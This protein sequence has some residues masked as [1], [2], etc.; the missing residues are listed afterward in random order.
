VPTPDPREKG[1]GRREKGEGRREEREGS[2][3][4]FFFLIPRTFVVL[5][6]TGWEDTMLLRLYIPL[7]LSCPGARF[8][9][10]SL[11]VTTRCS[12]PLYTLSMS[13]TCYILHLQWRVANGCAGVRY[14]VDQPNGTWHH[15]GYDSNGLA[16]LSSSSEEGALELWVRNREV[17]NPGWALNIP[18]GQPLD[19]GTSMQ[20]FIMQPINLSSTRRTSYGMVHIDLR[21]L[22]HDFRG[23]VGGRLWPTGVEVSIKFH[24]T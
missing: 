21:Y 13:P 22:A 6:L 11:A 16:G 23:G 10:H 1:E 2:F 17:S 24:Y 4:F 7:P 20:H 18:I 8:R 14:C 19:Q 15:C 12:N 5:Y 9:V 3:F